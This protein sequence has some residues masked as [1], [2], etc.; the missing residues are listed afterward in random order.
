MFEK[1]VFEKEELVEI[2]LKG[3]LDIYSID[4]FKNFIKDEIENIEKDIVFDL[5][6]LNYIDST[7]IGQFIN[8]YKIQKD[9]EKSVKIENAKKNIKK[10]FVITDLAKLFGMEE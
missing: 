3:E 8:I 1:E 10:L 2:K 6:N 4:N 9:K 5:D 7:G